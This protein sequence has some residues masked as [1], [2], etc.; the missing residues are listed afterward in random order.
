M[1]TTPRVSVVM[2]AF[3][4]EP[5]LRLAVDAVLASTGVDVDLVLVDNGCTSSAVRDLRPDPRLRV[6]VPESNLG[7][8]GGV[9]YGARSA[10]GEWLA[11]VNSDAEVDREAL[12]ELVSVAARPDVG[13]ASGSIRLAS[14]PSTMNSAGNP[15]HVVGL[16]W[17]GGLGEPATA[18]AEEA[19]V[20]SAS[21]AGLVLSRALWTQLGGF[22]DEY[23][24]YHEDVDLSWRT[25]QAGLRVVYVPDA[26]VVHHYEFSRNPLKMFL[27][28]KNR[29]VF[30][31]T[32][33]GPRLRA[34]TWL[35]VTALDLA[36]ELVARSQGWSAEKRR[37]RTW[38]RENSDWVESRR[39]QVQAARTVPDRD[40]VHLLT[41]HL[42]QQVF[43]LPRGAGVLQWAMRA[44]WSAVR[45]FV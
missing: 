2:L 34:V 8:A 40:L 6:V 13:I 5:V 38:L 33:Y 43:P 21:G 17:A 15:V 29:Q 9:N 14:D 30:L 31:R 42:D 12:S 39:R 23:F 26:V 3:G 20:A 11:L 24:A 28:E 4:D 7:F 18:H 45:R 16:S 37:A 27:L 32:A 10:E 36:M 25:W 35:P 41:A 1:T 22:A 44:Y 19:D